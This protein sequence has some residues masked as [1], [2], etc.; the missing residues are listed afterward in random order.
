MSHRV[1]S[2]LLLASALAVGCSDGFDDWPMA[3]GAGDLDAFDAT[4][5]VFTAV[6]SPDDRDGDCMYDAAE[7]L[8]AE[9]FKPLFVFDSRENVR[10]A[11][12]PVVLY[13][14]HPT[15]RAPCGARPPAQVEVTW[16]YLFRDDGGYATSS[17]CG[18]A[19]PGD[20]Q[21]LRAV[22]DVSADG[23]R[24]T[25]RSLWNWGFSF[26]RHAM[27]ALDRAH[28][29]VYLSAGKHHPF[30][31]T[32]ADGRASPYSS[33]GCVEALDGRG[34]VV[35][36]SLE[37]A[38]S[39]RRWL[40]VGEAASHDADAFVG[41]LDALGFPGETAWSSAPFCGQRPRDGCTDGTNPLHGIWD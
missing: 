10:R 27:R 7:H 36:P 20:D 32:R 9:R 19:H 23:A 24:F 5:P 17:V 13:Q 35:L 21:Y 11:Q 39:P 29:I 4:E 30:F 16:A 26:P 34:A 31:D 3:T 18:D 6:A 12:E 28:P 8:L 2:A 38:A 37:S 1:S 40:N 25:L 33:W 14:A 41:A 15:P 22:F